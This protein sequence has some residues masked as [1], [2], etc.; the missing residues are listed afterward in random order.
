MID[1][2]DAEQIE[3]QLTMI[4]E[5]DRLETFTVSLDGQS[6]PSDVAETLNK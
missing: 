6:L 1:L 2:K 3:K 5:E 4:R